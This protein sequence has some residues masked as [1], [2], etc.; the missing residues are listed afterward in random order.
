MVID[1][2]F[3]APHFCPGLHEYGPIREQ[4]SVE[5]RSTAI[6]IGP[7]SVP[8]VAV[9]NIRVGG[10]EHLDVHTASGFFAVRQPVVFPIV[11]VG[12]VHLQKDTNLHLPVK[13]RSAAATTTAN[14]Q[15]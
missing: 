8:R 9:P 4:V 15:L 7:Y 12:E 1:E 3:V 5:N 13:R 6:F 14:R 2:D 10:V 11:D